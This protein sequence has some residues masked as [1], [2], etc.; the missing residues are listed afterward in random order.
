[1]ADT[2]RLKTLRAMNP[3]FAEAESRGET[4]AIQHAEMVRGIDGMAA[5]RYPERSRKEDGMPHNHCGS[6]P[7]P[8]GCVTCDL[9]NNPGFTKCVGAAYRTN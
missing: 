8:E 4:W 2:E 5:R 1:M 9:P 6:C 3:D 7:H